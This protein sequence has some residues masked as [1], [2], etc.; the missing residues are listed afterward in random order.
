MSLTSAASDTAGSF[1]KERQRDHGEEQRTA[2]ISKSSCEAV[3][4]WRN[5]RL[6]Q[7]IGLA[8]GSEEQEEDVKRL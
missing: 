6:T 5:I 2:V 7:S 4:E 1:H 8:N 3:Y